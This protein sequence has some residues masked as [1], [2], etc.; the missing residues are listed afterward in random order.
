[1]MLVS[2]LAITNCKLPTTWIVLLLMVKKEC[3][4]KRKCAGDPIAFA[5]A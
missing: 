5:K 3:T 2:R 4:D 1:M